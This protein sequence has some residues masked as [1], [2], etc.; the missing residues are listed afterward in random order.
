MR[1]FSQALHVED[2][3]GRVADRFAEYRLGVF[4]DKAFHRVE[5]ALIR[6]ADLVP[7]SI[8]ATHASSTAVVVFMMRV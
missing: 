8:L 6:Q 3:A 5:I 1:D 4:V 7:P 2:I